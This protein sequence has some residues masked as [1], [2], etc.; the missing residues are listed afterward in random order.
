M[1]NLFSHVLHLAWVMYD[2]GIGD[3]A[4]KASLMELYPIKA[5]VANAAMK[6]AKTRR[7]ALKALK[8]MQRTGIQNQF[9]SGIN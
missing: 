8:K 1:A 6:Q 5:R 9:L 7:E 3:S 4:V 2:K